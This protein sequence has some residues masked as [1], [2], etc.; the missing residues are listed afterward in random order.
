MGDGQRLEMRENYKETKNQRKKGIS[1]EGDAHL[2]WLDQGFSIV[3]S[4]PFFCSLVFSL[5][6]SK[7]IRFRF[8]T[9]GGI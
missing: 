7:S 3:S 1:E 2:L 8:H 6:Q 5:I 4:D 9:S